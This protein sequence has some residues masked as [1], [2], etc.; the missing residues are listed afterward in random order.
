[1]GYKPICN[2]IGQVTGTLWYNTQGPIDP[3]VS[4]ALQ[5]IKPSTDLFGYIIR[6]LL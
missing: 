4:L 2:S 3:I 6:W 1:M 5:S